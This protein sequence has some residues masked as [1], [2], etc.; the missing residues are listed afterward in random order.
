MGNYGTADMGIPLMLLAGVGLAAQARRSLAGA[1]VLA[2]PPLVALAAA[3]TGRYP[4]GDRTVFFLAPCL[5][6]AAALGIAALARRRHGRYAAVALA[7][8]PL[9]LLPGAVRLCRDLAVVRPRVAF[10]E[11]FTFVDRHRAAGDAL[12]VSHPEVHDVYYG[13]D[14]E[15]MGYYTPPG[16][17]AERARAGRV[18][19]VYTPQA[20]GLS[21]F[22]AVFRRLDAI[23]RVPLLRHRETGLEVVLYGPEPRSSDSTGERGASAP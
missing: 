1:L 17:V 4:L 3:F 15:L 2:V 12:W 16:A 19:M 6:L 18:W 9:L 5:W 11:A 21:D 23:P 14:S 20:P 10:R 13:K 7:A 8:V 22:S